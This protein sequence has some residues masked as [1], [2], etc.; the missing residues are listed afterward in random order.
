MHERIVWRN[1][2]L[3]FSRLFLYGHV[4]TNIVETKAIY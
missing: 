4:D 2:W 3:K 1:L